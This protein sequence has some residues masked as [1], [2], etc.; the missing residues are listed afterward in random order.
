MKEKIISEDDN[1]NYEKNIQKI[2]DSNIEN[3]E[4][5]LT[6]KRKRLAKYEQTQPYCLYHGWQW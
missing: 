3:I 1:K 2:T 6:E 4:N 5:I